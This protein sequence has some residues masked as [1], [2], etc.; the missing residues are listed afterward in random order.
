MGDRARKRGSGQRG[1]K[2]HRQIEELLEEVN[3]DAAGVD[4]GARAVVICVPKGRDPKG[5]YIRTFSTLM[6]Q[7]R[8]ACEWMKQCVVKTVAME[9]TGVYWIP[10]YELLEEQGFEVYLV[11]A[12]RVKNVSGRKKDET[13]AEWLQK[14]HRYGL[15]RRAFRPEGAICALREYQRQRSMLVRTASRHIQHMH[16][17]LSQMGLQLHHVLRDITGV[18]GQKIVRA[19]LAGERDGKVLAKF[20]DPNCKNSEET[21]AQALEGNYREEHVFSLRQAVELYDYYQEKIRDCDREIE[22]KLREFEPRVSAEGKLVGRHSKSGGNEP[23]FDLRSRM[24]EMTGVDLTRVPGLNSYTVLQAVSETGLDMSRWKDDKHFTSWLSLS[25]NHRESGGKILGR[26]TQSS[27]N[28]AATVFRLGARALYN[29][30]NA[31][32]AFYRRIRARRGAPKAITA[33]ARK[34]AVIYYCMLRYGTEYVEKGQDWYDEQYRG[35][36]ERN[37]RRRAAGLGFQLVPLAKAS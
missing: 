23:R 25:P 2:R 8:K 18:T 24:F 10:L 27:A 13:D 14:L 3:L 32:G 17:A 4:I 30:D 5:Q 20:R 15:L 28:R 37:L 35:R 16:K 9:S 22:R 34:I 12:R 1:G 6:P 19:I 33:T 7:L 36:V 21:I 26:S 31:L 11:D 29:A